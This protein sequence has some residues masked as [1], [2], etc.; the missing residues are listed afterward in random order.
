M[1]SNPFN[2]FRKD[3]SR[4]KKIL[5]GREEDPLTGVANLFD[6]AMVLTAA[7]IL[8]LAAAWKNYMP[9]A[10]L[11]EQARK[12]PVLEKLDSEGFRLEKYRPTDRELGGEGQRL[13]TAYQLKNG[14]VVYV[15]DDTEAKPA[16]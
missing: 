11:A 14:D 9:P 10:N 3:N 13:G 16:E 7:L 5:D 12:D 6:V 1:K 2:R 15:P 8:A 4:F